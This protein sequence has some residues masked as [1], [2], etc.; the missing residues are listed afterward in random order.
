MPTN[1]R[2]SSMTKMFWHGLVT[3]LLLLFQGCATV[4]TFPEI[5]RPGDTVSLMVGGSED[6]RKEIIDVVLTDSNG[7][8]WDLKTLGLVRSVFNL[9]TDGRAYGLHYSNYF[10][11][12]NSWIKGHEPVQ[13][14]LVIDIP[15]ASAIGPALVSVNLNTQDDSSGVASPF[16]ISFDIVEVPGLAGGRND[17]LRQDFSGSTYPVNFLD[18][19]PAPHAKISFGTGGL[20]GFSATPNETLGAAELV[21]DFDEAIVSGDDLNVYVAE[22]TQRGDSSNS[23][24][25]GDHQRMVY[26]NHDSDH[27]YINVISPQGIE[28]RYLQIYII[29]PRNLPGDPQLTLVSTKGYDLN[30]YSITATPQFS[31]HP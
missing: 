18:L 7:V 12:E 29:H 8:D 4:H 15:S 25:F 30:G 26:W 19:E 10:D 17:F 1:I 13:T 2:T 28:D 31:Y 3:C 5:A 9:R 20:P 23:G 16:E 11:I 6:A 21:I 14:V 24:P 22:S 27:L